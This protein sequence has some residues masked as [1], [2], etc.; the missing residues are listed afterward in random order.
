MSFPLREYVC[1]D[2]WGAT[3]R[4]LAPLS[5]AV[6]LSFPL[7]RSLSGYNYANT[8]Y[9]AVAPEA[10]GVLKAPRSFSPVTVFGCY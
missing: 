1:V 4:H 6:Y 10:W 9:I 7:A 8:M 3:V 2:G 5:L